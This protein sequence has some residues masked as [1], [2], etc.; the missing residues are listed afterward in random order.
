MN[1]WY[2]EKFVN[3]WAFLERKAY[4]KQNRVVQQSKGEKNQKKGAPR[5]KDLQWL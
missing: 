2:L 3:Q 5:C 4:N 1:T